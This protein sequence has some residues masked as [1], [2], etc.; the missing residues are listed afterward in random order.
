MNHPF[1]VKGQGFLAACKLSKSDEIMNASGGSY[2]VECVE[3]EERQEV[4]YNFQV[5]DYHTYYV[6]ENSI[7]VH[8]D[9][10]RKNMAGKKHPVSGVEYDKD[11]FPIFESKYDMHL[12][13]S[14]YTK[15]RTTHFRKVSK[16]LYTSI[17]NDT[18]LANQFTP[19]EISLFKAGKVPEKYTWH[20]HQDTGRMQLVNSNLHSK[21]GHDGGFSIWGPGNK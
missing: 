7:L 1:Y 3:L 8:N 14:D 4:V 5:E 2:P 16:D 17:Q 9:C 11:G 10:G 13:P 6:G 15:S 18:K 12:D 20:H 19:E 21:T